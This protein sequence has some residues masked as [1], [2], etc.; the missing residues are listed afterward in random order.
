MTAQLRQKVMRTI[1]IIIKLKVLWSFIKFSQLILWG[2]VWRSVW[3]I[4][5]WIFGAVVQLGR[6]ECRGVLIQACVASVS[7]WFR[8][9]ERPKNG[10]FCFGR[11]RNGTRAKIFPTL[12]TPS[13][14]PFNPLPALSLTPFFTRSLTLVSLSLLRTCYAGY[15]NISA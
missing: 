11:A 2:N 10:I 6:D 12:P 5:M 13:K 8:S 4:S 15:G 7:V 3:R 1:K 9:K 14:F